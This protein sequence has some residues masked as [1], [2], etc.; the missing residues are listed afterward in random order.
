MPAEGVHHRTKKKRYTIVV[1]PAG[2]TGSPKRLTVGKLEL[3]ALIGGAIALVAALVLAILVYTPV[4]VY[5]PIPN[6]EL[7]NRYHKQ[8]IGVQERLDG[9]A[10]EVVVLREYNDRLRRALG[11]VSV[12]ND[13]SSKETVNTPPATAR[14]NEEQMPVEQSTARTFEGTTWSV[15]LAVS[16]EAEFP[17]IVPTHGYVTQEFDADRQHYGMDFAG[18]EGSVVLA[19][20]EGTVIFSGWTYDD[21]YTVMIAHGSGYRTSYKHNEIVSKTVGKTVHRGEPIALLGNSGQTSSGPH[22]HFEVWKDGT[23]HDP[24]EFLLPTE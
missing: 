24:R 19:A 12:E 22:L 6:P 20:A 5:V 1:L 9:L 4:G 14:R 16:T 8:V 10:G 23:P 2:E 21:G 11:E 13:S 7:E 17:M 3:A 18:K 15:Q